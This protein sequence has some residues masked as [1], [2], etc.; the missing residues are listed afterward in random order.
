MNISN[1]DETTFV[2][3]IQL[4]KF[5]VQSFPVYVPRKVWEEWIRLGNHKK[6]DT[7]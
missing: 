7:E 3:N 1:V 5:D 2:I 6:G 4:E